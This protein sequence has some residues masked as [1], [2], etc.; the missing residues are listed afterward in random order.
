M[1][2][3]EYPAVSLL[4]SWCDRERKGGESEQKI[5]HV[6][7]ARLLFELPQKMLKFLLRVK[8]LAPGF[9]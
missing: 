8:A 1:A 2:G 3:K 4:H 7:P 6:Q 5:Y 9:C